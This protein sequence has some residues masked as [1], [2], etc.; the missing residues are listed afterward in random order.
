MK[1]ALKKMSRF[2]SAV[3]TSFTP[4]LSST[5]R[6]IYISTYLLPL[7]RSPT[8]GRITGIWTSSL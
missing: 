6:T 5:Q 2:S 4:I 8:F 1:I 7:S 3:W